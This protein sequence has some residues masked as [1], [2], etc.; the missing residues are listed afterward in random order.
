MWL[1]LLC[2]CH[3][4]SQASY[5]SE[6]VTFGIE[7][8]DS[9]DDAQSAQNIEESRLCNCC[10]F[11]C[12]FNCFDSNY[13]S[14][15]KPILVK[16]TGMILLNVIS[17]LLHYADLLSDIYAVYVFNSKG[18]AVAAETICCLSFLIIPNF[19]AS[20]IVLFYGGDPVEKAISPYLLFILVLTGLY[21]IRS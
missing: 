16:D 3:S 1:L 20:F 18:Q 4:C 11:S 19:V 17:A 9:Q 15:C 21:F 6:K 8:G 7:G 2:Y 10:C 13:S 5:K 14:C 12:S